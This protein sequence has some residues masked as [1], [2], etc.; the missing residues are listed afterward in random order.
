MRRTADLGSRRIAL[1]AAYRGLAVHPGVVSAAWTL[2][3]AIIVE[4]KANPGQAGCWIAIRLVQISRV[5]GRFRAYQAD[6]DPFL[7][8]PV[9]GGDPAGM[10]YANPS[11]EAAIPC[12]P[13]AAFRQ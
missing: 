13:I 2:L 10:T 6:I 7:V 4:I 8:V 3:L 12:R 5:E 11:L 9:A 1:P